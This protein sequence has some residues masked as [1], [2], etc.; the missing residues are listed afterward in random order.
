[1]ELPPN[2]V[3]RT[4]AAPRRFVTDENLRRHGIGGP[5]LSAAVGHSN[6]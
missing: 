3:D 5:E 6:R 2:R 1:M 4:A